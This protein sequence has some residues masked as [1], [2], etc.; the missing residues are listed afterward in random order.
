[1]IIEVRKSLK[2]GKVYLKLR[3]VMTV[4]HA[5]CRPAQVL[6]QPATKN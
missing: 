1:M 2:R 3:V 5:P 4:R 6:L